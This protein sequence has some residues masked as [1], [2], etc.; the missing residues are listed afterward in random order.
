MLRVLQLGIGAKN[1]PG[2]RLRLSQQRRVLR[3]IGDTEAR[4]TSLHRSPQLARSA[5]A[6]VLFGETKTVLG[7]GHDAQALWGLGADRRSGHQDASRDVLATADPAAQ[8]MKLGEP[9]TLG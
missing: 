2:V 8:L 4:Q 7:R 5:Q 1:G 9:E 6:Q 3:Q